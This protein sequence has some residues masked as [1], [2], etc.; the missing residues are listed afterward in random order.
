[1]VSYSHVCPPK[2]VCTCLLLRTC[3]MTVPSYSSLSD[4]PNNIWCTDNAASRYAVSSIPYHLVLLSHDLILEL[5][6]IVLCFSPASEFYMPTFRNTSVPSSSAGTP[7]TPICLRRWDS[8]P[9][10]RHIKFRRRGIT[11]KKA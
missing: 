8:V 7:G 6:Q 10:R 3:H 5:P 9:K 11:Q 1:M 2:P 4:Y